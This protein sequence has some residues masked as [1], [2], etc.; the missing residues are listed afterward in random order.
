MKLYSDQKWRSTT[1]LAVRRNGKVVVAGDGQLSLGDTIMK[2]HA[3]KVRRLHDDRVVVGFAGASA[4]A[5]TLFEKFEAK[6]DEYR[7]NLVR[8]SVE[9]AKDWRMDRALRHLEALLIVCDEENTLVISG[10]GD[11]IEPDED[12]IAIGS[13]GPFA[14]AA[15]MALLK[16]T[17][18]DA[19]S[20][21]RE[22]LALAARICV[23]TNQEFVLEALP[24]SSEG[25]PSKKRNSKD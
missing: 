19:E 5:F 7:G 24:K 25:P 11:V 23:F 14:Q 15:A 13:G 9:L 6:L 18:M 17:D 22:S 10:N 20:I 8:S 1:I 16:F 21:A 2:N 4:D 12:V 3:R